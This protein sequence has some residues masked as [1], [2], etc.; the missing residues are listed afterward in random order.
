MESVKIL[1]E[2]PGINS[3]AQY[4]LETLLF[5]SKRKFFIWQKQ[6]FGEKLK[7]RLLITGDI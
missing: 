4:F 3:F 7:N 2:F 5:D 1:E 6:F